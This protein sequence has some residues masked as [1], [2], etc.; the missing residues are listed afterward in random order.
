M[1]LKQNSNQ[2]IILLHEIYGIN[3]H[4][5][6]YAQ[7][8]FQYGFD[9]Y[10]P[11]LLDRSEPFTY[12]EEAEAYGD[13]MMNVGFSKAKLKVDELIESIASKYENIR[14]IGFS[15]GATVG[16]LCSDNTCIG[17]MIGFYG[18]RIRQYTELIPNTK[19]ILIY[20][21]KEKSFNPLDLKGN[22]AL[23]TNVEVEI[24]EGLHGFADPY[25]KNYNERITKHFIPYLID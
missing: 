7:M 8:F 1:E 13:F 23:H 21:D 9:V 5:K 20:G 4:M 24:V 14:L 10:V 17:K 25:S 22:L 12:E 18:S 19:V 2:C 15:I 6:D 11:N 16:W 3:Q